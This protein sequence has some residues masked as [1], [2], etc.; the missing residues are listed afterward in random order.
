MAISTLSFKP[1]GKGRLEQQLQK[2]IVNFASYLDY[3]DKATPFDK[4]EQ[5]GYHLITSRRRRELGSARLATADSQFCESLYV[6]L[7]HW[8]IGKRGSL[9]KPYGVFAK[10]IA[11]QADEIAQ[12][13][14][15]DI[16]DPSRE[17]RQVASQAWAIINSLEIVDNDSLVV[18]GTKTLHH[19]LPDL[20]VPM[21]NV[22]TKPFFLWDY[23]YMRG[24]QAFEK[25]FAEFWR[26]A[27]D[28]TAAVKSYVVRPAEE[29]WRTS[30]TKVI[31]NAIVA[32][33]IKEG[34]V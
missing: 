18:S 2:L 13:E 3:F 25:S 17:L 27:G 20:V 1:R 31:D 8:G 4:P 6:T 11:S 16:G 22:Y 9:L 23:Q 26:I 29:S 33:C 24:Q 15:I 7:Q 19:L 12:L 21:D 28:G 5:L 32:Y 14:G 34:L 10:A 30:Q